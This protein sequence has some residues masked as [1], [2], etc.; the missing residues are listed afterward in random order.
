MLKDKPYLVVEVN[1][2]GCVYDVRLNDVSLVSD[3]RGVPVVAD[4]PVNPWAR[5]GE[6]I[7]SM[8]LKPLPQGAADGVAPRCGA[9]LKVHR[10]GA[11]AKTAQPIASL[12]FSG[13][14]QEPAEGLQESSPAG[15]FADRAG[16]PADKEEGTVF[17][18]EVLATAP[19]KGRGAVLR[20]G[21]T[22]PVALPRWSWL[23]SDLIPATS[24][25]RQ[26]LIAE[27]QR[28]WDAANGKKVSQVLPL[29][30]ERNQ[31]LAIAFNT[32]EAEM[33]QKLARL[34]KASGDPDMA[35]FPLEPEDSELVVFGNGRLA[36][37]TRW[38]GMPMIGFNFADDS[39]S[40]SF[41]IIYRKSGGKWV[42]TR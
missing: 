2:S 35:L 33:A 38:D 1:M 12:R 25:T 36:K 16:F 42:I 6:N 10:S 9:T 3:E 31:E 24:E 7:L 34:E 4:I 20:R 30:A 11:P 39:G 18:G 22:L 13:K 19:Q 23:Q 41:D 5:A 21:I 26:E 32:T 27:Y 37:L 40:E 17:V 8:E 15:R 29:F 28:I 14:L